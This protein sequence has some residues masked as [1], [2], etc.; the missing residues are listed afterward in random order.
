MLHGTVQITLEDNEPIRALCLLSGGLD[1]QLA[2]CVLRDQ[3]IVVHG[4]FFESP[5]FDTRTARTAGDA[6]GI[7]LHVVDFTADIVSILNAPHFGFGSC[8]NP[9]LDC[10]ARMLARAGELLDEQGFHF[11]ATGEVL[12]ERPM[13]QTRRG[14]DVVASHSG[15]QDLIVRPL[16]AGLLPE[17][18]PER[19]GWVDRSRLLRLQGRGRK[20][21]MRLAEQY[22]LKNYP[23]PAGG[24]RLTEPNFSRRLKDLKEHEGL[25]GVR[26]IEL[27]RVGRHFRISDNVKAVVGRNEADNAAIEGLAELYDLLLT[28][29]GMPGPTVLLPMT[30]DRDAVS[31]GAAICARYADCPGGEQ[32]NVRIRSSREVRHVSVKP[33]VEEEVARFRI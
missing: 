32:V 7:P 21:Q 15:R 27:L 6:L 2:V 25:N 19:R 26:S 14:L 13:S 10:H 29:E 22:G 5:F 4:V 28:T 11:L 31:L 8:M 9:C 18:E 12:N 3:G 16:S 30:A 23:S 17:T 1:S 33:A 20:N 24:C